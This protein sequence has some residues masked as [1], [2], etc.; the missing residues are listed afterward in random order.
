MK[1]L[2]FAF[3]LALSPLFTTQG[4]GQLDVQSI[5]GHELGEQFTRHHAVVDFLKSASHEHPHWQLSE[6]GTT[7]EG[8]PLLGLVMCLSKTWPI[9]RSS[10]KRT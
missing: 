3:L 8:R 1:L 5:I 4:L 9:W 10:A 2:H 7:S 6:Y